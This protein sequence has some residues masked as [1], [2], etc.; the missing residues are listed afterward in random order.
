MHNLWKYSPLLWCLERLFHWMEFLSPA[1][2]LFGT[3]VQ[4]QR[5]FTTEEEMKEA[6]LAR[7]RSVEL[8]VILWFVVEIILALASPSSSGWVRWLCVVLPLFR[9]F[10]IT[11]TA[12]NLN[13]FE[14]LRIKA[15]DSHFVASHIRTV[16][17]T[18]WNF[19]ELM[20]CFGIVYSTR[21]DLLSHA[22][23]PLDGY[24]FSMMTQ[25]T[26]G[27]GDINPV[28]WGRLLAAIQGVLGFFFALV[29]L[30]RLTTFL[31][32]SEAIVRHAG[33]DHRFPPRPDD[34][35]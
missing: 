7:G 3:R 27:Y 32:R 12:V 17:L 25:L 5:Q 18:L 22:E 20:F 35:Q 4:A 28:R 8:Y 11:Q 26:I 9:V 29:V 2:L 23:N 15:S 34:R 1:N 6:M 33:E 30:T 31:P 14:R 16:V 19:L 24:Y 13:I 21:L 10:E